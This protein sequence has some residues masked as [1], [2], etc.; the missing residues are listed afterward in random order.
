MATI[1]LLKISNDWS[2]GHQLSWLKLI[3]THSQ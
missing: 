2:F 1:E 3:A